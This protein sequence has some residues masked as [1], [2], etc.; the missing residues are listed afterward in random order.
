MVSGTLTTSSTIYACLN[1]LI[2][3]PHIQ[4]KIAA[5]V[6]SLIGM[7]GRVTLAHRQ[8][9]PYTSACILETLR[10][11]NVAPIAIPH[12]TVEDTQVD[13]YPIKKGTG[14][15]NPGT[16]Y[17]VPLELEGAKLP[18]SGSLAPFNSK[19]TYSFYMF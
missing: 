10:F 7:E 11:T 3:K 6:H 15:S 8:H 18:Q 13:G 14:V 12:M 16:V 4:E 19:G 2:H 9:M 1:I 5:E 17:I